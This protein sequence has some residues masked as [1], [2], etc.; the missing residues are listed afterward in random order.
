MSRVLR[1]RTGDDH[2]NG[3]YAERNAV[4]L[5]EINVQSYERRHNSDRARQQAQNHG[6]PGSSH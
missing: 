4:R 5:F 3:V 6:Q 1:D 2:G